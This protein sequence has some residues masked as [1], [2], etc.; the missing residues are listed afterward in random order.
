MSVTKYLKWFD[1]HSEYQTYINGQDKILPNVSYCEDNN[2]VHYNPID[3]YNGHDYVDLGLPSGTLW[4]T[5]N[6]GANSITDYGLYFSWG[7]TIGHY[8][9]TTKSF[10]WPDYE[11]GYHNSTVSD[12]N[13]AK[14]NQTDG[15]TI[16]EAVDDAA[17]VNMGGEWHMPTVDQINELRNTTYVTNE[18]ITNYQG[19]GVNGRLFTSVSDSSKTLFLPASGYCSAGSQTH[20]GITGNIWT[21]LRNSTNS[22]NGRTFSFHSS[23]ISMSSEARR[24][25]QTIRGVVG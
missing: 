19:S 20:L 9:C 16:L 17:S 4:A 10:D 14:Y 3:P 1:T 15:L 13:M 8:D 25:G 12:A 2:E 24:M 23:N 18:W 7:G 11:L 21:K 6:V 5:K 22:T